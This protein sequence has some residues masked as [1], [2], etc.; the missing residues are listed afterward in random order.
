MNDLSISGRA[1]IAGLGTTEFSKNSGRTEIRLAMEATLA[2]LADAGIDPSEVDGFSSYSIDKVPE[3]EI[4]RLLGA[5]CA[6]LERDGAQICIAQID[7]AL[8]HVRPGRAVG[9]LEVSHEGIRPRVEGVDHHLA[10]CRTGDF[11]AAIL[12]VCGARGDFPVA[13]TNVFGLW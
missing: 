13:V 3:Y 2:A 1:S 5:T 8:N 7:L 10:V 11:D 4:A 12:N 6:L 9:V